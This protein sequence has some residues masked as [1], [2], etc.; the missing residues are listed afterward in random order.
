MAD[1]TNWLILLMYTEGKNSPKDKFLQNKTNSLKGVN[2]HRDSIAFYSASCEDRWINS[3][4]ASLKPGIPHL[5]ATTSLCQHSSP[6]NLEISS[7]G[8]FSQT[9][10]EKFHLNR[11][12]F[13]DSWLL[14]QKVNTQKFFFL[15][16]KAHWHIQFIMQSH[17]FA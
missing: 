2:F 6:E 14:P 17:S 3:K 10:K 1:F 7:T 11:N 12:R 13:K 4:Q 15:T 16:F 5:V 9:R 8:A